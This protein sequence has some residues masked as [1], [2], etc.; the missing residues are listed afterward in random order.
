[1]YSTGVIVHYAND[2]LEKARVNIT[3]RIHPDRQK[4]L[5][6]IVARDVRKDEQGFLRYGW[7]FVCDYKYPLDVL[8]KRFVDMRL[9]S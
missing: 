6:M 1:M 2:S 5:L 8:L 3:L 9:L 7:L 4:T